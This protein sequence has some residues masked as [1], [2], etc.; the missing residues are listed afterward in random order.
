MVIISRDIGCFMLTLFY[1]E[2]VM[3]DIQ[4]KIW[5]S[6]RVRGG[7][8]PHPQNFS[9]H[10]PFSIFF[11][12]W[13]KIVSSVRKCKHLAEMVIICRDIGCFMLAL[14]YLE[15]L[16]GDFQYKMWFSIRVRGVPPTLSVFLYTSSF[17]FFS[18]V[19]LKLCLLSENVNILLKW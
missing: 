12:S 10:L 3:G 6:I 4:Y 18:G 2:N 14:F 5:F 13:T 1:L 16:M 19:E 15:N 9:V 11:W 8:L 7:I 17:Q